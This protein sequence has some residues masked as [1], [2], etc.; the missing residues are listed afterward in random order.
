MSRPPSMTV[1]QAETQIGA[2]G[3]VPVNSDNRALVRKWLVAQ[4]FPALFVAALSMRELFSAY[5]RT[6]GSGIAAVRRKLEESLANGAAEQGPEGDECFPLPPQP[7]TPQITPAATPTPHSPAADTQ[8]A[9]TLL[10][11]LL[12][13]GYTPGF[14]E[15]R[16][17]AIVQESVAGIAPRVIEIRHE[18]KAPI[19]IEGLVHPEFERCLNYLQK[20]GPNGFKMNVSLV[21]PAGCGKTH[22]HHQLAK[23]LGVDTGTISGSAGVS[24]SEVKGWLLP[25]DG[26][27]FEYCPSDFVKKY[28][29]GNVLWNWD[30]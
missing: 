8:D 12:L 29:A 18:D 2:R 24:E 22:L 21:G 13:Q 16:V 15:N 26:G 17:R 7:Q 10:R 5:N 3:S 19:K 9:A 27:R 30:E 20:T 6:D 25:G 4:G 14:D 23:A 11:N 28:E 1:E